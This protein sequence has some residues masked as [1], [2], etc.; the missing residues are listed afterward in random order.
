[1]HDR[2]VWLMALGIP[3]LLLYATLGVAQWRSALAM[4]EFKRLQRANPPDSLKGVPAKIQ[5]QKLRFLTL[6]DRLAPDNPEIVYQTALLHLVR[7][8]TQSLQPQSDSADSQD[9]TNPRL[10]ASLRDGLVFINRAIILNPGYAEYEFIKATILQN[11]SGVPGAPDEN[12]A[13]RAA[14]AAL[15]READ[16]LDPFKPSL[17]FRI[18]SFWI[19]LDERDE[20]REALAITLSDSINYAR[21]VFS[22]LWSFVGDV[23][24]L[25]NFVGESS[26]SQALLGDFLWTHGYRE[27][28]EVQ[29][30]RVEAAKQLDYLAGE[31]LISHYIR[32][33]QGE[34]AR[35]VVDRMEKSE[36]KL[37]LFY[38]ARL[39][40]FRGNSFYQEQRYQE[41]I[42]CFERSLSLDPSV[43]QSHLNLASAYLEEGQP[44][45]AIARWRFVL[46]RGIPVPPEI[47]GPGEI[48]FGLGRA[49]EALGDRG[50]ALTEYL[51]ASSEDPANPNFSRKASEITQGL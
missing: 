21:P 13:T 24:D 29:F 16:R 45:K 34:R 48:H 40:Y 38:Q 46:A 49:Y 4:N 47:A 26:M 39:E 37:S 12:S 11:L 51:R 30:E 8:E 5:M 10:H 1:M 32:E 44:Q 31:A 41:A 14:V 20:A 28:A 9:E 36:P 22:L 35:R 23:S 19:A 27:E 50:S 6:A 2:R 42:S 33:H 3:G 7:A 25:Q 15:L 43:I 18:G 17:H